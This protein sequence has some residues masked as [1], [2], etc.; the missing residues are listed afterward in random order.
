MT[1]TNTN[2]NF[3]PE[4]LEMFMAFCQANG[5]NTNQQFTQADEPATTAKPESIEVI[6]YNNNKQPVGIY[7]LEIAE[8]LLKADNYLYAVSK[9]GT[10]GS[11][12][13]YDK[14]AGVYKIESEA[15]IRKNISE[16]IESYSK[17]VVTP[18]NISNVLSL[19]DD[20]MK[21]VEFTEF[22]TDENIINFKNGLLNV[23]TLELTKHTPN[24]YS[25]TQIPVNWN[26]QATETKVFNE[27]LE[28]LTALQPDKEDVKK[29]LM[30]F[31]GVV[32]S[33][34]PGWKFKT[35]LLMYG[36]G[37]TGKS[38]LKNLVIKM[39]GVDNA[40]SVELQ[41]LEGERGPSKCFG[42]R[43]IGS[44]DMAFGTASNIQNFKKLTGGDPF[45]VR[46]LYKEPFE[47]ILT[48]VVWNVSNTLPLFAGDKGDHVYDRFIPVRCDNVIP[49]EKRDPC[50]F[51]KM[52]EESEGIVY[53]AV[54]AMRDAVKRNYKYTM[55]QS[56]K[57][58]L[59]VYKRENNLCIEFY[60]EF[61]VDNRDG[62]L[63]QKHSEAE[64]RKMF[65][66]WAKVNYG[67]VPKK[68]EFESSIAS[69][70]NIPVDEL[71][72]RTAGKRSYVFVIDEE[73]FE[74]W[75]SQY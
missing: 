59:K 7:A 29:V 4:M 64:L 50:I 57:D 17:I 73:S 3:T 47:A 11:Y 12:C 28:T 41:E 55:P 27:Y 22:D 68:N 35:S 65:N 63:I 37:N 67:V 30:E 24:Y 2:F 62:I 61:C 53:K 43:I 42:K 9:N 13:K 66:N 60:E 46:W 71:H 23:E 19:M 32:I 69:Y 74:E 26:P 58:N 20:R 5:I 72:H 70:L 25:M 56:S 18:Q 54:L 52:L 15:E 33:N 40:A 51:S 16:L 38:Q 21:R 31:I 8:Y 1:N 6:K 36:K 44:G 49:E 34:V 10:H 48:G 75:R 45:S 14:N 39:I